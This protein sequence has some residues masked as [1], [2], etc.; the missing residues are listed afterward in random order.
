[1]IMNVVEG[2]QETARID[3]ADRRTLMVRQLEFLLR[4]LSYYRSQKMN[5]TLTDKR[6]STR[7]QNDL[8]KH[9]RQHRNVG[10]YAEQAC[11]SVKHFGAVIK[12]ETGHS[13][14]YWIHTRVVAEAKML[15]HIRRDL[16]V[17][18]IA[19]MLGF[20]E[21]A[22]F[23]RYFRRETGMSPTEFREGE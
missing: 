5:E 9:F 10:F 13:A 4:L 23:S 22:T 3:I 2:M 20:D 19:D 21:Q 8:T 18:A 11:L 17:Q 14:S 7:F 16:S 12:D 6:I 15:L 1:M